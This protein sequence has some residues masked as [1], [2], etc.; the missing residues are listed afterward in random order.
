MR[1]IRYNEEELSYENRT[2]FV[3]F[4][5]DKFVQSK[6]DEENIYESEEDFYPEERSGE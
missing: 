6:N 5:E 2:N 4:P 3:Y 1:R